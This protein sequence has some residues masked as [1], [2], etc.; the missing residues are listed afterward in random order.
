M[1]VHLPTF[2]GG[3]LKKTE[4]MIKLHRS[5]TPAAAPAG[6]RGAR[7]HGPVSLPQLTWREVDVCRTMITEA[8]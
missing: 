2:V 6:D 7:V 8:G 4:V 1:Y 3:T 5:Q